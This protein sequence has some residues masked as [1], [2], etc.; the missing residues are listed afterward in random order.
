MSEIDTIPS[1]LMQPDPVLPLPSRARILGA[2]QTGKTAEMID[3]LQKRAES[4]K[5]RQLDPLNYGYEPDTFKEFRE[6]T[7]QYDEILLSGANREGKTEVAAKFCVELLADKMP[8]AT[9]AFFHSSEKSS[10]NQ[11]QPKIYSFL[12]PDWRRMAQTARRAANKKT[13]AYLSYSPGSGF[14]EDQF[15]LPNGSRGFFFNYKQDVSVMEGYEFDVVWFDELVPP[16]FLEALT[17]RLSPTKRLLIIITFTPVKGFTQVVAG[18]VAGARVLKTLPAALLPSSKLLVKGCPLGHMPYVMEGR[19]PNSVV[20]F[21]HNKTNLLGGWANVQKKLVGATENVIK[22]RAYG[23][24]DKQQT[25]VFA[26]F[27]LAVHG[28]SKERWAEIS[29]GPGT[30]YC[31]TDPRPGA[32][33]FIKWYFVTPEGWT[34]V[35]REWPDLPRFGEWALPPLDS[36]E[37]RQGR[38]WRPGP[39]MSDGAGRGIIAYKKIVLE[40]E[41]WRWDEKAG[42]WDDSQAEKIERRLIDPRMGGTEIPSE[43]EGTSL[44][45]LLEDE[46]KDAQ[47][48]IIGPS[49]YWEAA[50]ASQVGDTVEMIVNAMDYDEEAPVSVMNC[51]KW[52][53]GDWCGQS[54]LT[55]Q[56]FTNA[57]GEKDAL[58]DPVDCDRYFV[59]DDCGY[60]AP[61]AMQMRRGGYY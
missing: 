41:G 43:D 55:Y 57:G 24:A 60:L 53:V 36:S 49:L 21:L 13:G 38:T 19:R 27:E 1:A 52:Y 26:K 39:A 48:R 11:Q 29:K 35:Y 4:I 2:V 34:I 31:V 32:N 16:A 37:G 44:I 3:W 7:K 8:G 45:A 40:A 51:P 6:L 22:V 59:K 15:I 58:K 17:F 23:W 9:G 5:L 61:Q 28:V 56:E 33:W 25:G 12:P 20:L 46:Q 18:Y 14:T 42:K 10:R 54:I 47:G 30:R 50:P